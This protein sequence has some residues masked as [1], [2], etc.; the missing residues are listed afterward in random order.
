MHVCVH[1]RGVYMDRLMLDLW[2][3][4]RDQK[5]DKSSVKTNNLDGKGRCVKQE[6]INIKTPYYQDI[7][8]LLC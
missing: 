8:M 6:K 1:E 3:H 2:P 4:S 7:Q 5:E